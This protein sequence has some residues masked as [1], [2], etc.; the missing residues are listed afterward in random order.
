MAYVREV[1]ARQCYLITKS[2]A[3]DADQLKCFVEKVGIQYTIPN[4][5]VVYVDR[6]EI[7]QRFPRPIYYIFVECFPRII[8]S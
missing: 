4:K 5:T 8:E 2:L 7:E 6:T 1:A 3:K